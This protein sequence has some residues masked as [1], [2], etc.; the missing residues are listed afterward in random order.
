MGW[1]WG[2]VYEEDLVNLVERAANSSEQTSAGQLVVS[3]S[4]NGRLSA[5]ATKAQMAKR[6]MNALA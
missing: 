1:L 5:H 4:D 6:S 2:A 3:V